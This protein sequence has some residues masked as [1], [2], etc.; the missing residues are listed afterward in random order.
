MRSAYYLAYDPKHIDDVTLSEAQEAVAEGAELVPTSLVVPY[1][2]PTGY[3]PSRLA[4]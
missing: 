3:S 1:S 2:Y 4:P